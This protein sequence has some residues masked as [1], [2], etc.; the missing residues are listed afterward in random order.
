MSGMSWQ[1]NVKEELAL[2]KITPQITPTSAW[3][4]R[5]HQALVA[6]DGSG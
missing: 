5:R 6:A 4:T 1:E 2:G 3:S